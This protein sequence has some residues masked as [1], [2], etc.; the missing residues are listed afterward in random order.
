MGLFWSLELTKIEELS[1]N[2][3]YNV[4][5]LAPQIFT[6][7]LEINQTIV[8]EIKITRL[9]K[10]DNI[11]RHEIRENGLVATLF[12][13]NDR[14]PLPAIIVLGGSEGGINEYLPALLSSH[15]FTVFALAYFGM[16]DLPKQ[17]VRIPLE[18]MKS[19][20]DWIKSRPEA[21]PN[22]IGIPWNFQRE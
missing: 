19:A 6:L 1:L 7:Y 14:T 9:W 12:C 2:S 18:Y 4:D 15:G 8:H 13:M 16:E 20:I 11:A 21:I 22:W 3:E 17:V 5:P 10:S